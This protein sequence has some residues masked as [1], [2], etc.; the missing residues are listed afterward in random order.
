MLIVITL[1]MLVCGIIG[2]LIGRPKGFPAWRFFMGLVL[3]LIGIAIIAL[4]PPS[5]FPHRGFQP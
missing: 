3:G 5:E 1:V 4:W 2:S